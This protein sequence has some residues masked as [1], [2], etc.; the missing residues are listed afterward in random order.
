MHDIYCIYLRVCVY[1][2]YNS[3]TVKVLECKSTT[4]V[5]NKPLCRSAALIRLWTA[6]P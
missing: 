2:I 5:F 6:S 3:V 4:C 1:I